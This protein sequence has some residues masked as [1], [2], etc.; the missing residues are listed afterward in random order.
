M[1]NINEANT[2]GLGLYFKRDSLYKELLRLPKPKE[3]YTKDWRDE[4][5]LEVDR[6]SPTRYEAIEYSIS[7]YLVAEDVN[8]LQEKRENII[9]ILGN[10]NGF[11]LYSQTLGREYRL[12]YLDSPSFR[13]ITPLFIQGRIYCEFTLNLR[14]NYDPTLTEFYLADDENYILTEQDEY[15]IVNDLQQNF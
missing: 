5:G 13:N 8:D 15:I 11:R 14:N 10:P 1:F 7:C 3:R 2:E 9:T 6:M 4:H 12:D